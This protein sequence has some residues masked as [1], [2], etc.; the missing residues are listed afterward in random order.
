MYRA[1]LQDYLTATVI[2]EEE[3]GLL[4]LDKKAN[5]P[6]QPGQAGWHP[7]PYEWKEAKDIL[8]M[9]DQTGVIR[10]TQAL[11]SLVSFAHDLRR[12]RSLPNYQNGIQRRLKSWQEFPKVQYEI[13]VASLCVRSG[14]DPTFILPSTI[15]KERTP[16][17]K[18]LTDG[19]ALYIECVRKDPYQI[20]R[21]EED[22]LWKTL[23]QQMQALFNELSASHEVI[24]IAISAINES[25]IPH[26]LRDVKQ[27]VLAGE[28]GISM[29]R[30]G[31]YG[32]YIRQL[33]EVPPEKGYSLSVHQRQHPSQE[34]NLFIPAGLAPTFV[35]GT[36]AQDAHGGKYLKNVNRISLCTI[37][38]HR[39][40][41][42]LNA[43]NNKRGQIAQ[44]ELG[45]IN[46]LW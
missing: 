26:I 28:E 8:S 36:V 43:F 34:M 6:K 18:L 17:L 45:V 39:L 42:V 16:D 20:K 37:D 31:G 22:R 15:S 21:G 44:N 11:I 41:S 14:Y 7:I 35:F 5:T 27:R 30:E 3:F 19:G 46:D 12:A 32:L 23:Q 2:I 40:H 10:P 25:V 33:S 38:S 1:T 29:H 24:V 4:W 9:Y 13:Y